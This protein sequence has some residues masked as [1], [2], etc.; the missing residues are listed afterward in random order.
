MKERSDYCRSCRYFNCTYEE[1]DALS[2]E[3]K[4]PAPL[5]HMCPICGETAFPDMLSYDICPFC[6]WEHDALPDGESGANDL[7]VEEYRARYNHL[8]AENP[9][10][11]WEW[12]YYYKI[13]PFFMDD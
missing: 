6:G 9:D 5:P 13:Y 10:Y 12:K 1:I 7:N 11:H 4:Q 8:V 3:E 2:E